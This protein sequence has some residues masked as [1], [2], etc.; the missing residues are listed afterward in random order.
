[1]K[2]GIGFDFHKVNKRVPLIIGGVKLREN[3]GLISNTDGDVLIHS[4]I[5]SILGAIGERDIGE[6]FNNNWKGRKSVDLLKEVLRILK[7]NGFE[8]VNIDSV[9]I[10]EIIRISDYKEVIIKNLSEIIGI[11]K[12][13][14]NIK[15]KTME[16]LGIIGKKRGAASISVV[17][18]NKT[19]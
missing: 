16:G 17:L 4:I 10:T 15:G 8:I 3:Y 1:M 7:Q 13:K 11:E 19:L 2:I 6:I 9:I 14:I 12:D 5:D 18:L